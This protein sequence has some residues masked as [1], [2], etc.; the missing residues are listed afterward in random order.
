MAVSVVNH[1][2]N[3]ED[4]SAIQAHHMSSL[5]T[6][7]TS[8][9][10]KNDY[11]ETNTPFKSKRQRR[12]QTFAR[13]KDMPA[14][15]KLNL[16]ERASET[17]GLEDLNNLLDA[18]EDLDNGLWQ[19]YGG[20][21]MKNVLRRFPEFENWFGKIT[22]ARNGVIALEPHCFEQNL[23][24]AQA[25]WLNE[26][27]KM[28]SKDSTFEYH[29]DNERKK[30]KDFNFEYETLQVY[31]NILSNGGLHLYTLI[32]SLSAKID[33]HLKVLHSLPGGTEIN[34][35][36][37][38]KALLLLWS[39]RWK[40][41]DILPGRLESFHYGYFIGL[42]GEETQEV[43]SQP[44]DVR[45]ALSRIFKI[46]IAYMV[47]RMGIEKNSQEV[48]KMH[49]KRRQALLPMTEEKLRNWTV[50]QSRA[51]LVSAIVIRGLPNVIR[52]L[53]TEDRILDMID[54][55]KN[56]MS[57]IL[58]LIDDDDADDGEEW[59]G[60]VLAFSDLVGIV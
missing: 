39:L 25:V 38:R 9:K 23:S 57:G 33:S 46:L 13:Y 40:A 44:E 14:E 11:E 35:I 43:K 56:V 28:R 6:S 16:L 55:Y 30:P 48:M 12:S 18:D 4:N 32:E 52:N 15:I 47:P 53:Q 60:K 50:R 5:M 19:N 21:I 20:S 37:A 7:P 49:M 27:K 34:I 2:S 54:S 29:Q 17:L 24:L 58:D 45:D 10:R 59:G 41:V 51:Y 22:I 3:P 1:F 26:V 31:E 42:D 8:L 36:S